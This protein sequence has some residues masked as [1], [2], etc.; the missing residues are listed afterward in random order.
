MHSRWDSV[1]KTQFFEDRR[2]YNLSMQWNVVKDSY[3]KYPREIW[4]AL[5]NTCNTNCL[6]CP[7]F[8]FSLSKTL[9]NDYFKTDKKIATAQVENILQYA[10]K[11]RAKCIFSGPGDPLL[12]ERLGNFV[13]HAKEYGVS[14]V[15]IATN[16][17][18]LT[19]KKFLELVI[20]GVDSWV[21]SVLFT[22][23]TYE[24]C[25]EGFFEVF[26]QNLIEIA[27]LIES[28]KPS[29]SIHF[30]IMYEEHR[31]V[32]MLVFWNRIVSLS[33]RIKVTSSCCTGCA[34]ANGEYVD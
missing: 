17:V 5:L 13:K 2:L 29:L 11:A 12:D 20:S 7:W 21:I 19:P 28:L 33:H 30:A 1:Y 32:E 9:R 15:E 34:G 27:K 8:G 14:S 18:L 4:I 16:G 26:K 10:G 22:K 6:F 24:R 25:E 23:E 31:M 3:F